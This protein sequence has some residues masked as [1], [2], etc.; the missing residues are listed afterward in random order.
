MLL[1]SLSFITAGA[2]AYVAFILTGSI[3]VTIG[4]AGGLSVFVDNH[5][6]GE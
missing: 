3:A 2:L 4:V 5:F 1:K 6:K